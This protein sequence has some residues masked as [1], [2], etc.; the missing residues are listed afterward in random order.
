MTNKYFNKN[1]IASKTMKMLCLAFSMNYVFGISTANA[2]NIFTNDAVDN[3]NNGKYQ[4]NTGTNYILFKN[5]DT[6]DNNQSNI[7][8]NL[9]DVYYGKYADMH[10]SGEPSQPYKPAISFKLNDTVKIKDKIVVGVNPEDTTDEDKM[11]TITKDEINNLKTLSNQEIQQEE[12]KLKAVN[13]EML[14]QYINST[15]T[16][17]S[18]DLSQYVKYDSPTKEKI[19]LGD[20]NV[21][22]KI[23]NLTNGNI[24]DNSTDAVNGSQL[25]S[26]NTKVD[27][28]TNNIANNA[29]EIAKGINFTDDNGNTANIKQGGTLGLSKADNNVTVDI[30]TATNKAKIGLADDINVKTVTAN[31]VTTGAASMSTTGINAGNMKVINVADGAI[32]AT[33]KDA[34]NGSQLHATN[35]K[36]N[37]NTTNIAKNA[38]EIAKGINFTDDNGNTA[39][40]KQGGTLGLSKADANV[41]VD[42]DSTT[43]KAKIGLADNINVKTVSADSVTTGA[44]S[45]STTGINA[46]SMKVTNVADGAINANSTDAVN[47]NQLYKSLGNIK[48]ILGGDSELVTSNNETKISVSDIGNT[49]KNTIHDAIAY[50]N[51]R[52]ASGSNYEFKVA[53][54]SNNPQTIRNGNLL[55]FNSGNNIQ[56]TQ[57]GNNIT[58]GTK[59]NINVKNISASEK[60]KVGNNG[61]ELS[62]DGLDLK[63][64]TVENLK[65][66]QDIY[67]VQNN[68]KAVNVETLRNSLANMS[69]GNNINIDNKINNLNNKI[70]SYNKEARAGI[71]GAMA[72]ASLPRTHYE[73]TSILSFA[74]GNFKGESSAAMG[75]GT[76]SD[77]G[78]HAMQLNASFNTQK[79]FGIGLGY[80]YIW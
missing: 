49:G 3:F 25:H 33:S 5:G 38:A 14:K 21:T 57:N 51:G 13:V 22:T 44:A 36:V 1:N 48:S 45:M 53:A 28:N 6:D 46:G 11:L 24:T 67:D 40:I 68:N 19:T 31:S 35:T 32:N 78:K 4:T 23:T 63:G 61:V 73:G 39:N 41:T 42:I 79:D 54:D 74:I 59:E 75:Y 8:I 71:A 70:Q 60:V 69:G 10:I 20:N 15:N 34:V 56:L 29:A 30:D 27:Q 76:L 55:Q 64:G 43:N 58:I 2:V 50:I 16:G 66:V 26:T 18:N 65:T 17:Q 62:N 72:M 52:I 37:Q 12:N 7:K 77:N 47:G 80:G 9:E